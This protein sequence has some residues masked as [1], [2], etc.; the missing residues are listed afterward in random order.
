MPRMNRLLSAVCLG[1]AA[2]AVFSAAAVLSERA[3][4]R[5]APSGYAESTQSARVIV[6]FKERASVLSA[7]N[8]SA[9]SG[10]QAAAT[11]GA[12]IGLSLTDGRVLGARTQVL[13]SSGMSSKALAAVVAQDSE[14]EW[15]EVDQRRFAQTAPSDP[16]Y[17][18][19]QTTTTPTVGQW[20]L[21]APTSTTASAINI[22]P[23]W[24]I[25]T[26][27]ASSTAA[28][29]SAIVI[30]DVD[31]GITSHPDLSS[32]LFAATFS[33]TTAS[34]PYGYDFVGYSNPGS[35]DAIL[36]ANDGDGADA[37]PTDPGDWVTTAEDA[38]TASN[39][40][41]KG[42]GQSDSSWH[43]TETAGI[44][45]AATNN[46][47]GMAG[48]G[49]GTMIVPVRAL[50]KCGGYT[51]D[52]IAAA[53]WAGG[54]LTDSSVPTNTHPARVINMSLGSTGSCASAERDALTLLRNNKVIVVAAA[55][56]DEGLAV[57]APANCQPASTDSDQTPIVIA[58]AGLRNVGDKVGYSD[59]GPEVTISAPAGNCVNS[60]GTCLYPIL[61][62]SNTGTTATVSSTYTTGGSN[63]SLGTSF[64]TPM[65]A[66][67]V[68]LML[69]AAP[70]L[71][72]AQVVSML[73]STATAFPTSGGTAGIAT[74]SAPTSTVQD[75]CY[76]TTSTCGAGMLNAGAAVTVAAATV[77]AVAP[78]ATITGGTSVEAGGTLTL[79]GATSTASGSS[80]ASY[81]WA[82]TSGSSYA[83]L[84][85][86]SGSSVT[87]TGV[88]A[89]SVTV[90]LTVLNAAGASASTTSTITVT[91]ASASS[92]SST[93]S[94]GS[95]GG[96]GAT[97]PAW[98]L[99]L[100]LAG[101]LL[102]PRKR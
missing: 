56:N 40:A 75:E 66:G 19:G 65:V 91:A 15:A 7:A 83:T 38:G 80:I 8:T 3:P 95:S 47:T 61:T 45:G 53:E 54:V 30:A 22:E 17:A 23:A 96:G 50:G 26:N 5:K 78:V 52:I 43:G 41:F 13:K 71:T 100:V 18:D 85:A 82:I 35:A 21:R 87:L 86:T 63:A 64:A 76:C 79:S 46:A 55:G 2:T 33:G 48:V 12:R 77:A 49:Y 70:D 59:I 9:R 62:T 60:T 84:S 42:C 29:G 93:T 24:A 89:G 28:S 4:V 58:V 36:I 99:L 69:A 57:D 44:L 81:A 94:S 34:T 73:K 68:A 88:A 98:L 74:C 16:L 32:K 72:N 10:P 101:T 102:A 37:D 51:S 67:T 27:A 39:G 11:L 6:K 25:T 14:V 92:G 31:T 90:Q 97:S 1:A 20:Y